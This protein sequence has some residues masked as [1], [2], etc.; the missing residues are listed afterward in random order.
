MNAIRA[1][2]LLG[3]LLASAGARGE[4]VA[5]TLQGGLGAVWREPSD[6]PPY[7][8]LK[9]E[10]DTGT[11]AWIEAA[12]RYD[13][14][15]LL[16]ASYEYAYFDRLTALGT[17]TILEDLQQHD[18][19]L[20]AFWA[21]WSRGPLDARIGAG[22]VFIEGS[23]RSGS[24]KDHASQ[25]GGFAEA[26]LAWHVTRSVSLDAAL[27]G[28]KVDGDENF[29]AEGVE[30]ALAASFRAGA[31]DLIVGARY[32]K[33]QHENFA[34]EEVLELRVGLGGAW[35]WIENRP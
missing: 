12:N 7:D 2:L 29:D 28:F 15:L 33:G 16:R 4:D 31:L 30:L 21:P 9:L 24:S 8:Q 6:A 10:Y 22:Y 3:L 25:D 18:A 11:L 14:G 5:G 1:G 35:G 34:D 32:G 23:S 13:Y 20:G 26:G 19:R 27:S 17:L